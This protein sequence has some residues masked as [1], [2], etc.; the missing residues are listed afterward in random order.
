MPELVL[1]STSP[2]RRTLLEKLALPF[3]VAAPQIDETP[4][5]AES[6]D[7]L[8]ARLA[9]AKARAL[10]HDWPATLIIGS[11]QVCVLDGKITG[12]PHT[13]E[14]AVQQL[15]KAQGNRV[16]FSTGLAL[17]NAATDQ[18]QVCVEHYDVYFRPL[19]EAE[20]RRYIA[21][22]QPL[23]CAGSFK[24]EGLGVALFERM[25][26]RDPNS[27]IGLPLMCLCD[28]LRQEGY[29]PLQGDIAH[30]PVN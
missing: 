1:A 12:K 20:I 13:V 30:S 4:L 23:T 21:I 28:M 6:A 18:I 22:E 11:D 9:Q 26:G 5:P 7:Q 3:H 17:L 16:R 27:L 29:G 2:F 25:E 19:Q 15:M 14:N 10:R 8:V 24:S